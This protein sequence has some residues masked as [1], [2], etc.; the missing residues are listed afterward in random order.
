MRKITLCCGLAVLM[1]AGCQLR[2]RHEAEPAGT[3]AKYQSGMGDFV[4]Y[5]GYASGGA[6]VVG[7]LHLAVVT[8]ERASDSAKVVL[9]AGFPMAD[10]SYFEAVNAAV[11]GSQRVLFEQPILENG[12]QS[13]WDAP[14]ALLDLRSNDS[15]LATEA[16]NWKA[17]DML[18]DNPM[19]QNMLP[20]D[21]LGL[22]DVPLP[23]PEQVVGFAQT[24]FQIEQARRLSDYAKHLVALELA[25][26]ASG[27][28]VERISGW[29][30]R[31][32]GLIDRARLYLRKEENRKQAEGYVRQIQGIKTMMPF[33]AG[34]LVEQRNAFVSVKVGKAFDEGLRDVAIYYNVWH[35]EDLAKRLEKKGFSESSRVWLPAWS[36][37]SRAAGLK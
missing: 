4:R 1:M 9:V 24:V 37:N 21:E 33:F 36:M 12:E 26:S 19:M 32:A 2:Y 28:P 5:D 11:A 10:A 20:L 6:A 35:S 23:D 25:Q 27:I 7:D 16:E 14:A 15:L 18:S 30:D 29:L 17:C 3:V 8:Y 22:P 31:L 34:I 13:Y